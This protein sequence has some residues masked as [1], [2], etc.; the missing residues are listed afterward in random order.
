M[1]GFWI[2]VFGAALVLSAAIWYLLIDRDDERLRVYCAV[3]FADQVGDLAREFE[4]ERGVNVELVF[5]GSGALESQVRLAGGDVFL[6]ADESYLESL[7]NEFVLSSQ[8]IGCL[9]A[10]FVVARGNPLGLREVGDLTRGDVKISLADESASVGRYVRAVLEEKGCWG[11]VNRRVLVKKPTVGNVVEDV[12]TGAV[13]V[14]IAWRRVAELFKEVE[15][16]DLEEF[17]KRE[18][19]ARMGVLRVSRRVPLARDFVTFVVERIR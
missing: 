8:E 13:D 15:F 10:G 11:E 18:L 19:V 5:G 9:R 1:R 6:P 2:C 3:G 17:E 4:R 7:G 14:T 12:A 16:V